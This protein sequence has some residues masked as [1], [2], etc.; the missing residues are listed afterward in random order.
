MALSISAVWLYSRA[1]QDSLPNKGDFLAC[2]LVSAVIDM[3]GAMS[4]RFDKR[5]GATLLVRFVESVGCLHFS[6]LFDDVSFVG[7]V[8]RLFFL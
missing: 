7:I 2:V 1:I 6:L 3:V 5:G 8:F 4:Y